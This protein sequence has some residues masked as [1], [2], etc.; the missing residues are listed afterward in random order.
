MPNKPLGFPFGFFVNDNTPDS[1][2]Y[3]NRTATPPRPYLNLAEVMSVLPIGVRVGGLTVN[4]AG[5]QYWWLPNDTILTSNPIFKEI[6][7]AETTSSLQI[8][9]PLKTIENQTL[10]GTGNIDLTKTDIGLP[11]VDNTSDANKPISTAQAIALAAKAD[12][13]AGIVPASQSRTSNLTYNSANGIITLTDARG[14]TYSIDLPIENLFQSSSYNSTTQQLTLT[15]NGG[16]ITVIDLSTLVDIAEI[17]VSASSNPATT[18]STGQKIY[19]RADNGNYWIA[20]G[21]IW[22]G[23]FLGVNSAEKVTWNGKQNALGFTP[24]DTANK[25][26]LMTGNTTSSIKFL[27]ARGVYDWVISLGYQTATAVNSLLAS[28]KTNNYLDAT[29][30]IQTQI[31]SKQPSGSYATGTGSANGTNTGDQDLSGKLTGILATDIEVQTQTTPSEDN[32][33]VS[34]SKLIGWFNWLKTQVVNISSTWSFT[35]I[36]A[37]TTTAKN[38]HASVAANTTTNAQFNLAPSAMD[39]TGTE[40][41]ALWNNT[42]ELKFYDATVAGINR[43]LKLRGN[44]SLVNTVALS[45]LT[46]NAAG[47]ISSLPVAD[48]FGRITIGATSS[49][50]ISLTTL[51]FGFIISCTTVRTSTDSIFLPLAN[52]VSAGFRFYI[53]DETGNSSQDIRIYTSG[54][55][56]IGFSGATNMGI[57]GLGGKVGFYSDGVSK[58]LQF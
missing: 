54:S 41:G 55:D 45:A 8:K 3:W 52:S 56:T 10:E 31:N 16:G 24:E 15:T 48:T 33:F 11:N 39:Y 14:I 13:I 9:R 12:L 17:V 6:A 58:W 35:K 44:A 1:G 50:T 40:D 42:S 53:Y 43:L 19:I 26:D 28:F 20:S 27:S 2:K 30:S 32:K 23:P 51:G 34:Q 5:V 49:Y 46:K 36:L 57:S 22:N 29:S 25:S 37:G 38:A 47:D 18:P 4:V 21:G 7:T